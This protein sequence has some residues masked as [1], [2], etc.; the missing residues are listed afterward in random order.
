MPST[1]ASALVTRP[2]CS[3]TSTCCSVVQPR[4]PYSVGMFVANSPSSIARVMM[5][6]QQLGRH[7]AV[8]QLDLDLERDQLVGKGPG[9]RLDREVVLGQSVHRISRWHRG[10]D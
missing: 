6:A 2:P 7:L 3:W 1:Q 5:L 9:G 8:G 10:I 4:P